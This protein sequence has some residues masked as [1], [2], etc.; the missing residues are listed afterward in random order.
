MFSLKGLQEK[1]RLSL[2]LILAL[3][4]ILRPR[5][6]VPFST[7]SS[8][9]EESS[10]PP[11]VYFR[12]DSAKYPLTPLVWHMTSPP[13]P[14]MTRSSVLSSYVQNAHLTSFRALVVLF[15]FCCCYVLYAAERVE[16]TGKFSAWSSS[17]YEELDRV[18]PQLFKR[19]SLNHNTFPTELLY[20][21]SN[22]RGLGFA[23]LSEG[24][25]TAK[26]SMMRRHLKVAGPISDTMDTLLHNGVMH[27]SQ[28]IPS[29]TVVMVFPSVRLNKGCWANSLLHL[30]SLRDVFFCRQGALFS[31]SPSTL[32]IRSSCPEANPFLPWG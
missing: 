8:P 28:T 17:Q 1:F 3:D 21:P 25:H 4:Y 15:T 16:Y 10:S 12:L 20:L 29:S 7:P 14:Y 27:T 19:L 31:Y 30:A 6:F 22:L 11:Y 23:K 24:I 13:P 9:S 26:F 5:S 2:R 18:F 32:I